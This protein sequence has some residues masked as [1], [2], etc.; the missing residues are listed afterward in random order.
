MKFA[1]YANAQ[2]SEISEVGFGL[3]YLPLFIL[4]PISEAMVRK[5][6]MCPSTAT[7]GD[8]LPGVER[9]KPRFVLVVLCYRCSVRF[10]WVLTLEDRAQC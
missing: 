2:R 3:F 9:T 6:R 8:Q 10:P 5:V 1:L 4:S 7:K